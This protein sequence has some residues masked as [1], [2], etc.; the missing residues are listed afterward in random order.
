MPYIPCCYG[1]MEQEDQFCCY[2]STADGY[3]YG[4]FPR[5][6][7]AFLLAYGQETLHGWQLSEKQRMRYGLD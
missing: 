7:L 4:A 5:H 2:D 6:D 3:R 1:Y